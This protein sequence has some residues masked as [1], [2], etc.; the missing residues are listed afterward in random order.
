M[1]K[2]AINFIKYTLSFLL[3]ALL[4]YFAFKGV[5]WKEFWNG[6]KEVR[7][8]YIFLFC[9]VSIIA[10]IFR[11]K[12]WKDM[13]FPLDE[14][15]K[16]IDC[17]DASNVGNLVNVA[18]P[19]AG[20]FVR[21]GY[22]VSDKMS[23]DKVLGTVVCERAWDVLAVMGLF[24]VSMISEW[25]MMWPFI[26]ENI[27]NPIVL[28]F[29]F[30]WI[31]IPLIIIVLIWAFL[32]FGKGSKLVQSL[33]GLWIGIKSFTQMRRKIA[34]VLYTIGIW[35]MYLLMSYFI[36]LAIPSL[37]HLSLL[38]ALFI[39]SIGNIASIVPVPG[40]IGAYHYLVAMSLCSIYLCTW[41]SG[42]LFATLSHGLH[43]VLIIILGIVSYFFLQ[44]RRKRKINIQ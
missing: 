17:W 19:G 38:D 22:L 1:N 10:L 35:T 40:G 25:D 32:H 7:W 3:A 13:M 20:E 18:L 33:S 21:C 28:R 11:E 14:R 42:L 44:I 9:V 39:S 29:S 2:K 34:F 23:Y 41:E 8:F 36:F 26:S 4:V 12:R 37:E 5:D 6:L 31:L 30:W 15:V 16:D 24:I 27:I 43:A